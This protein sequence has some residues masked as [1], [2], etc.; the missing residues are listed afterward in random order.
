MTLIRRL[1]DPLLQNIRIQAKHASAYQWTML[2]GS[3]RPGVILGYVIKILSS[4]HSCKMFIWFHICL[5]RKIILGSSTLKWPPKSTIFSISAHFASCIQTHIWPLIFE[6]LYTFTFLIKFHV[7]TFFNK[8][9]AK[10][11]IHFFAKGLNPNSQ[12]QSK[13][14]PQLSISPY[15]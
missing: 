4:A 11:K 2:V 3:P 1:S 12:H 8:P 6:R 13:G 14:Q 5:F 10:G 7:Y 15:S 9:Q